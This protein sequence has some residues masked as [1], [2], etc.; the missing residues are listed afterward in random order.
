M[1]FCL[2][3]KASGIFLSCTDSFHNRNPPRKPTEEFE[4][5]DREEAVRD[6]YVYVFSPLSIRILTART[7]LQSYKYSN[8]LNHS[9]TLYLHR[10]IPK[11]LKI[12]LIA[13]E[14]KRIVF[15]LEDLEA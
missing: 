14:L 10:T 15:I 1:F 4:R 11:A 6:V 8:D 7:H 2:M 13:A 5:G 12:F 3:L 9:Q